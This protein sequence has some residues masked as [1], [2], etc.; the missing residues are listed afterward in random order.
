LLL[1]PP[2]QHFAGAQNESSSHGK[3]P[4]TVRSVQYAAGA[5]PQ[6]VPPRESHAGS[7]G[8]LHVVH[9]VAQSPFVVV[10]PDEDV[11][12][13]PP[14]LEVPP[15]EVPPPCDSHVAQPPPLQGSPLQ[16]EPAGQLLHDFD[17]RQTAQPVASA[18]TPVQPTGSNETM[19]AHVCPSRQ[20]G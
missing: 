15:L 4:L 17:G 8:P 2:L 20:H 13:D 3:Q 10:P 5:V 16:H 1:L 7:F 6:H 18:A 11:P 19:L 14:E 12:L 9:V